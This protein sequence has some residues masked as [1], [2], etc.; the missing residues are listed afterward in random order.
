M[1]TTKPI[2]RFTERQLV[3]L[4]ADVLTEF[5]RRAGLL[6][7]WGARVQPITADV[8]HRMPA[9]IRNRAEAVLARRAARRRIAA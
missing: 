2:D 3:T 6:A 1:M 7:R 8:L 4:L 9:D 5:D